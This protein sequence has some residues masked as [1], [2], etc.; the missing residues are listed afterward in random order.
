[1]SDAERYEW[2]PV[3]SIDDYRRGYINERGAHIDGQRVSAADY[4]AFLREWV[5]FNA[6]HPAIEAAERA[7]VSA[8]IALHNAEDAL[9]Q[10]PA[11]EWDDATLDYERQLASGALYHA[12][13]ALLQLRKT[14]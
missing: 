10:R 1:M 7:V 4:E 9:A 3:T 6:R 13:D 8:A 14:P 2:P 11:D 5:A 12:V